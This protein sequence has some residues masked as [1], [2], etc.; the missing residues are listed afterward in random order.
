MESNGT[1]SAEGKGHEEEV[2]G[3]SEL[4]ERQEQKF[5]KTREALELQLEESKEQCR[6]LAE[7]MTQVTDDIN[8]R[9]YLVEKIEWL[10]GKPLSR[11]DQ[12]CR[13]EEEQANHRLRR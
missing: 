7:T 3:Y 1:S 8:P 2:D 12:L 9:E 13:L 4:E 10:R 6:K 5:E 11:Q